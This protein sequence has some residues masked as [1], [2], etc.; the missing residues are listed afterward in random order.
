[1]ASL[2]LVYPRNTYT[3]DGSDYRVAVSADT[4]SI[5]VLDSEGSRTER[6]RLVHVNIKFKK[7]YGKTA[8]IT[9][10][11]SVAE[12]LGHALILAAKSSALEPIKLSFSETA[13]SVRS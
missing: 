6:K 11:D 2:E 9:L 1:M 10:P 8:R 7:R 12:E 5:L 13:K 3:G 4:S